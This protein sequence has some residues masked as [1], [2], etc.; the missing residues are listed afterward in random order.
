MP[1]V[2]L[3]SRLAAKPNVSGFGIRFGPDLLFHKT[4]AWFATLFYSNMPGLKLCVWAHTRAFGCE[5]AR[6]NK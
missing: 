3:K 5:L 1:Q 2:V 6:G 4:D